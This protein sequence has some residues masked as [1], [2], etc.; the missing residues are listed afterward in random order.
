MGSAEKK[1]IYCNNIR[2]IGLIALVLLIAG[3]VLSYLS[4]TRIGQEQNQRH[5]PLVNGTVIANRIIGIRAS[6]PEIDYRYQVA[7]KVYTACTDLNTP[8]FG[9]RRYRQST[10]ARILADYPVGQ[11]VPVHYDPLHPEVSLLRTGPFWSDYMQLSLGITC[12][13]IGLVAGA[14][15]VISRRHRRITCNCY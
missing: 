12:F 5:W 2:R 9:N 10:A 14:G 15:T 7:D 6:R 8:G 4:I 13:A 1:K 11:T 3:M